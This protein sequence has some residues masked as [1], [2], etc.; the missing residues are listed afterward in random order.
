M[1]S[2]ATPAPAS[3]GLTLAEHQ[4]IRAIGPP[5]KPTPW[6]RIEWTRHAAT[7][8][9]VPDPTAATGLRVVAEFES[10]ADAAIGE[11]GPDMLAALQALL[12]HAETIQRDCGGAAALNLARAAVNKATRGAHQFHISATRAD[13]NTST[14][15]AYGGTSCDHINTAADVAGLGGVVRVVPIDLVV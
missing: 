4:A 10:E 13:G 7:T 15:A 1:S 11:A 14:W 8:L 6:Q 5:P 9:V 2:A 3:Q 12:W